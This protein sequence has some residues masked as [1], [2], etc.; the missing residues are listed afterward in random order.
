MNYLDFEKPIS[1]LVDQIEKQKQIGEK[2]KVNVSVAVR[3]LEIKL[4]ETRKN[5]YSK[6]TPW[7]K[8]QLSRHPD[9][10]YT[11]AYI[12]SI[13]E[14][15]FVELYGDRTVKDDK[16]IIGGI[17]SIDGQSVMIIGQQKGSTTKQRQF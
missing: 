15:D 13:T 3:Q 5:L 16:A 2:N 4:E 7:Q 12:D 9:R 11:L 6:L 10:P 17:G 1:D 8:V 14:K